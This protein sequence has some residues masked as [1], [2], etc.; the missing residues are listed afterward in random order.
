MLSES[1]ALPSYTTRRMTKDGHIVEV[2]IIATALV[3]AEGK[4]YAIAT[5]ERLS[6]TANDMAEGTTNGR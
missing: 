1:V 6:G 2:T 4:M 5:T 3:D